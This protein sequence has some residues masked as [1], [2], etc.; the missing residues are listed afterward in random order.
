MSAIPALG[1][2][3]GSVLDWLG[4]NEAEIEAMRVDRL[5]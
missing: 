4:Y 3:T 1:Q 5:V 2:H